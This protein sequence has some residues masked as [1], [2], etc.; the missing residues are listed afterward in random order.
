MSHEKP[1]E[2]FEGPNSSLRKTF[3]DVTESRVLGVPGVL[4]KPT[5][6]SEVEG[7]VEAFAAR[8]TYREGHDLH[9]VAIYPY[10]LPTVQDWLRTAITTH[11]A[12]VREAWLREEIVKLEGMRHIRP[13][14]DYDGGYTHAID[15]VLLRYQSEL[16]QLTSPQTDVTKN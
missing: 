9:N 5:P 11:S 1:S 2:I 6:H 4:P 15:D 13:L 8:F 3:D 7:L 10:P 14:D 16:Y 12:K